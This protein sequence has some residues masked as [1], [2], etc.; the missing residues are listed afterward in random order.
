[1]TAADGPNEPISSGEDPIA[2]L[3][4]RYILASEVEGKEAADSVLRSEPANEPRARERIAALRAA[5]LLLDP[6]A[7]HPESIGHFRILERIGRGGMGEV[8]LAEQRGDL[9]RRVAIK[10]I[11]RGMDTREV[12][13]R[14]A[15]ERQ[16]LAILDHPNIAKIYDAGETADGRPY[17]VMEYV[18]GVPITTYCDERG[19]DTA[20]RVGLFAVVCE[21]VQHAHERGILHRDLKPGN[22]LVSDRDGRP[23]PVVIDFG[24][25]KSLQRSGSSRTI[26]TEI[27][28]VLGTPEYMSPEQAANRLDLD[29]RSDVFSLGVILYELL[30]GELPVD[31]ERLRRAG[32]GEIEQILIRENPPTPSTRISTLGERGTM[33]ASRR[34]TEP[35]TL[36]RLLRGD[37]DWITMRALERDRNRRYPMAIA[38]ASDLRR[39]LAFEPVS[40]GPPSAWYRVSR[41]LRRHR[42]FTVAAS[43]VALSLIGGFVTSLVFWREAK[44]A[45]VSESQARVEAERSLET[46][47]RAADE[48]LVEV[49]GQRLRRFPG[50]LAER[51]RMLESGLAF[52]RSVLA[53]ST[54]VVGRAAM[55]GRVQARI[56]WFQHELDLD[57]EAEATLAQILPPAG[58]GRDSLEVRLA[59]ANVRTAI[60]TRHRRWPAAAAASGEALEHA[61]ALLAIDPDDPDAQDEVGRCLG[62]HAAAWIAIDPTAPRIRSLFA[63]ANAA[64]R[65]ALERAGTPI[66]RLPV[67]LRNWS[68]EA[69]WLVENLEPHP[70]ERLLGELESQWKRLV[71]KS[72]QSFDLQEELAP[73]LAMRARVLLVLGKEEAAETASKQ[74]IEIREAVAKR[75]PDDEAA[76]LAVADARLLLADNF[77]T[78][79]RY[80][81]ALAELDHCVSIGEAALA[82]AGESLDNRVRLA[83]SE[84]KRVMV[85]VDWRRLKADLDLAPAR[86]SLARAIELVGGIADADI[87]DPRL[88]LN[89]GQVRFACGQ[90]AEIDGDYLGALDQYGHAIALLEF[91]RRVKFDRASTDMTMHV[92]RRAAGRVSMR[93]ERFAEA[94]AHLQAALEVEMGVRSIE[95][96]YRGSTHRLRETLFLIALARGFLGRVDEAMRDLTEAVALEDGLQVAHRTASEHAVTIALRVDDSPARTRMLEFAREQVD[97]A[98]RVLLER[99]GS[100]PEGTSGRMYRITEYQVLS[101]KRRVAGLLPRLTDH[102][103]AC[104]AALASARRLLELGADE[105]SRRWTIESYDALIDAL[106][107]VGDVDRASVARTEREA[108]RS[109]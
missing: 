44:A 97:I 21:T 79:F 103:E 49:G 38:I 40:A 100:G 43:V 14:F 56:A 77:V 9:K 12:L 80:R 59:I 10:V 66:A 26:H 54:N 18:A 74:V 95:P 34:R 16:T 1:M 23:W 33:V 35:Q 39:H 42:G 82:R 19:L 92:V 7:A 58:D 2:D 29:T 31:S 6:D 65:R 55:A 71:E 57:A 63:E 8:Y 78:R 60:H 81:E 85:Y 62:R 69:A 105:R 48:M 41:L 98:A 106:T 25:A 5:G 64:T 46:A 83:F 15:L 51:R 36:R 68:I 52:C 4:A 101:H 107:A 76:R 89:L 27:G 32:Q 90:M 88:A 102:V 84:A 72:P 87:T 17:L 67:L 20:D 94:E 93:L 45:H 99:H 24:V 104:D 96:S 61:R 53:D 50:M 37:L 47:L 30:T 13:A 109:R 22:I 91:D 86:T 11:R 75:Y 70:A 108:L 3:V 73:A 28:R